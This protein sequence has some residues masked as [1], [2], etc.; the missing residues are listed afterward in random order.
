MANKNIK[1]DIK[2]FDKT[3]FEQTCTYN[4][5]ADKFEIKTVVKKD[6][7]YPNKQQKRE[8][9]YDVQYRECNECGQTVKLDVDNRQTK[10]NKT[11]AITDSMIEL[12]ES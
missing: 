10:S 12:K 2:F 1:N 9:V 6:I 11:Q 3:T 5:C 4:G 7:H 8:I